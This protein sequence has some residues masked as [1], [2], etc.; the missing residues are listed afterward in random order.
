VT[1]FAVDE[2]L[3]YGE[4]VTAVLIALADIATDTHAIR[5]VLEDGDEEEEDLGE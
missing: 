5:R 2:P 1:L 3:I 4:E